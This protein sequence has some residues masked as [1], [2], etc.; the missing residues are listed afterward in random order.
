MPDKVLKHVV[1]LQEI[2]AMTQEEE[3]IE[4]KATEFTIVNG[5][6]RSMICLVLNLCLRASK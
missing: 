4:G 6:E 3:P 5:K 1:E 2:K